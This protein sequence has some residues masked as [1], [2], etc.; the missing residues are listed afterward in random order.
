MKVQ[1]VMMMRWRCE[2][3]KRGEVW[4]GVKMSGDEGVVLV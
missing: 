1:V 4:K 2:E 3:R